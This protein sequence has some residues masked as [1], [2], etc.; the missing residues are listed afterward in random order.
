MKTKQII[1]IVLAVLSFIVAAVFVN[2]GMDKINNYYNS[3]DF[4]I[5]NENA[6][7][8]GDAYNYIINANYATGYYVLALIFV[9]AGFSFIVVGYLSTIGEIQSSIEHLEGIINRKHAPAD[10]APAPNLFTDL[11]KL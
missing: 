8:G 7:V 3:E 1:F 5:L 4:S 9:V 2:K 11:P 10:A 6:Y